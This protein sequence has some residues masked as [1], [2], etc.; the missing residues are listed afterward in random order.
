MFAGCNAIVGVGDYQVGAPATST[1]ATDGSGVGGSTGG[2][3]GDTSSGGG[4]ASG[5]GG[6]AAG[7]AASAWTVAWSEQA[8]VGPSHTARFNAVAFDGS[9][10]LWVAGAFE[11]TLQLGST[12]LTSVDGYDIVLAKFAPDGALLFA[13]RFG[14]VTPNE[15]KD[16]HDEALAVAVDASGSVYIAGWFEEALDFG[17]TS[18]LDELGAGDIFVAKF[19]SEGTYMWDK[20][21]GGGTGKQVATALAVDG[22]E[23]AVAGFFQGSVQFLGNFHNSNSSDNVFV[24]KLDAG[25]GAGIWDNAFGDASDGTADQ[26]AHAIAV[27]ADFVYVCGDFVASIDT[28]EG[29]STAGGIASDVFVAKLGRGDGLVKYSAAYGGV[30]S[31]HCAAVAVDAGNFVIAGNFGGTVDFTGG[32]GAALVGDQ[33]ASPFITEFEPLGDHLWSA[34]LGVDGDAQFAHGVAFSGGRLLAVGS[35]EGQLDVGNGVNARATPDGFVVRFLGDDSGDV[36]DNL[37]LG[38]DSSRGFAIAT[39]SDGSVAIV[40]DFDGPLDVAPLEASG[41]TDAFVVVFEPLP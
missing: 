35:F 18:P 36:G 10:N 38:G 21:F 32:A 29:H 27:D 15:N 19:S 8:S 41:V 5:G 4:D 28:G 1:S 2:F 11:G 26:S 3:G 12:M 30:E 17:G 40:G 7:G 20:R 13:E 23:L 33:H 16:P 22:A 25:N 24:A 14:D 9:G 6:S 34:D 37:T 31:D 39:A